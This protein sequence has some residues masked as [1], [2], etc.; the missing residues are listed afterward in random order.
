LS[1]S[2][3]PPPPSVYRLER[4]STGTYVIEAVRAHYFFDP[5]A[6]YKIAPN[7]V[8]IVDI[9]ATGWGEGWG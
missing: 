9:V 5:L 8:N 4:I 1:A 6:D 2:L 3:T 7:M